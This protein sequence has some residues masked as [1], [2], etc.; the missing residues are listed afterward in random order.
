MTIAKFRGLSD[1]MPLVGPLAP[2][3]HP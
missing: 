2:E 1:G 3:F